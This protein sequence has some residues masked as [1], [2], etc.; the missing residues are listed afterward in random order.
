M[1]T[2]NLLL[3]LAVFSGVAHA[4]PKLLSSN[5]EKT[6]YVS[7]IVTTVKT[8]VAKSGTELYQ[9]E[10]GSCYRVTYVID[11]ISK[12][13]SALGEIE[14]PQ[15]SATEKDLNCSEVSN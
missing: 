14:L 8:S 15:T 4:E 2:K 10:D 7:E 12:R 9:R 5:I 6:E 13:E 3:T 11:K 1:K